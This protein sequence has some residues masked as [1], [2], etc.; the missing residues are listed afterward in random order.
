MKSEFLEK[1]GYMP[2][3]LIGHGGFGDVWLCKRLKFSSSFC[4][5]KVIQLSEEN[6]KSRIE[7]EI[8]ITSKL[9]HKNIC[10]V[11]DYFFDS[12]KA[13]IVFEYINGLT[14]KEI[15]QISKITHKKISNELV[16]HIFTGVLQALKFAH[17]NFQ[18]P[19]LHRDISPSNIMLG[20][21]GEVKLIDFGISR[22][23]SSE[24]VTQ[25]S[26][27]KLNYSSPELWKE[28]SYDISS[29]LPKHDYYSL[30][31]SLKEA[32]LLKDPKDCARIA[33]TFLDSLFIEDVSNYEHILSLSELDY[34]QSMAMKEIERIISNKTIETKVLNKPK[35]KNNARFLF[36][37]LSLMFG[38]YLYFTQKQELSI[39]YKYNNKKIEKKVNIG[40]NPDSIIPEQSELF[41]NIFCYYSSSRLVL[42]IIGSKPVKQ[43]YTSK[44]RD[45]VNHKIKNCKRTKICETFFKI[46]NIKNIEGVDQILKAT[47]FKNK[48]EL[49]HS[50]STLPDLSTTSAGNYFDTKA[51]LNFDIITLEENLNQYSCQIHSEAEYSKKMASAFTYD[52][53]NNF[54]KKWSFFIVGKDSN[55][56]II[57]GNKNKIGLEISEKQSS[58]FSK[59]FCISTF[60][61]FKHYSLNTDKLKQ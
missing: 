57:Q 49:I 46:V 5:V 20:Q 50:L 41:C 9:K 38:A 36:L 39:V 32:I 52:L 54:P 30:I 59:G 58:L 37:V 16:K 27:F 29:F 6:P 2:L 8:N 10:E 25:T 26:G 61:D 44:Q 56:Q 19:I 4:A 15:I 51:I 55:F 11:Y 12:D 60:K 35:V 42:D 47:K 34:S 28:G 14:L 24:T 45:F 21:N 22:D 1:N 13:Y 53:I 31:I 18:S 7:K 48:T 23:T 33:N 40:K 43:N 3:R 17:T